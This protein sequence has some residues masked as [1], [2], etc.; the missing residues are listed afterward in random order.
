MERDE[1]VWGGVWY[2]HKEAE[3]KEDLCCNCGACVRFC[4]GGAFYCNLGAVTLLGRKIPVTL[5]QSDRKRAAELAEMLK[6]N[7]LDGTF[8]LSGPV[9]RLSLKAQ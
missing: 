2:P 5:R 7:I 9:S 4:Q 3:V 8:T 6:I 1:Q